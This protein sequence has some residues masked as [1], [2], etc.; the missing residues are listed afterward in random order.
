[1]VSDAQLFAEIQ[2]LADEGDYKQALANTYAGMNARVDFATEESRLIRVRLAGWLI[3]LGAESRCED[4]IQDGLRILTQ[5]RSQLGPSIDGVSYDYNLGNGWSALFNIQRARPDFR[6]R[7]DSIKALVQAKLHYWRA[8]RGLTSKHHT[9]RKQLLVNLGNLLRISGRVAEALP[10]FDQVLGEDACF[11][12]AQVGRAEALVTLSKISHSHT[13]ILVKQATQGFAVGAEHPALARTQRDYCR[14]KRDHLEEVLRQSNWRPEESDHDRM[15]TALEAAGHSKY[16]QFCIQSHLTLS[17]HALYCPCYGARRDG[18]TIPMPSTAIGGH[19]TPRMEL[20]LNRVK[21]EYALARLFY[22]QATVVE[23]PEWNLHPEEVELT[24][25]SE[26]EYV[27]PRA[28]LLRVSFRICFGIL[29]KIAHAVCE[30]FHLANPHEVLH[31][32]SF[33]RPL[34]QSGSPNENARWGRL[35]EIDNVPLLALYSQ[36]T[37]LNARA[38]E[39][40][41]FKEW[42]NSLE[43]RMCIITRDEMG[44]EDPHRA[45]KRRSGDVVIPL[46]LFRDRSLVLLRIVRSAVFNFAFCVRSEAIRHLGDGGTPVTLRSKLDLS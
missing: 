26:G 39:W 36:A 6:M 34:S 40:Q 16:R 20:V 7:P 18:L 28:E 3:D 1:M 44:G 37:D 13:A 21:S 41:D 5:E 30:L 15:E 29:D 32:E 38:G 10:M 24:E 11:P 4:P 27:G 31:F 35:N 14:R 22:Y 33:W 42:R 2:R 17:E 12:Q 46:S 9:V 19:F 43:H 23:P 25:L 8:Y 45:I